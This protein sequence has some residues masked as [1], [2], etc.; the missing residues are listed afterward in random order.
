MKWVVVV[1][2]VGEEHEPT[3]R[4]SRGSEPKGSMSG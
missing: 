3:K 2:V 1:V 4:S